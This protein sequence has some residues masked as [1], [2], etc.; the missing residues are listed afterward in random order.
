MTDKEEMKMR[1]S[2]FRKSAAAVLAVTL[3][4]AA[5]TGCGKKPA[6]TTAAATQAAPAATQAAQTAETKAEETQA[7]GGIKEGGEATVMIQTEPDSFDPF[8]AV[9]ADTESILF[10]V[11]DGLFV[12]K[13]DGTMAPDLAESY[14]VSDDHCTYTFHL[15]DGATF[16]NG[17]P[18]TVDDVVWTYQRYAEA[19]AGFELV[20]KIEAVDDKTMSITLKEPDASF[21]SLLNYGVAPHDESIDLNIT[22][23][24]SG[25]Y[26]ITDYVTGSEVTLEKNPHYNTNPDRVPHLDKVIVKVN[27][28]DPAVT[29]NQLMAGDIDLT[30]YMEPANAAMVEKRGFQV[31]A[32]P[33]NT[34]QILAFNEKEKPFDDVRVRQAVNYAVDKQAIIDT[35]LFGQSTPLFSHMSPVMAAYYTEDLKNT[36]TLDPA[37]AKELLKEAGYE[38]G[39]TFTIK[40]PSN[41]KRHVDTALMIKDQLAEVGINAE[42]EQIEWATWLQDVYTDRKFQATVVGMGGKVDPDK[43]LNRYES[44]YKRNMYNYN[45]PEYDALIAAGK[46]ETDQAK[47]V[48]IYKQCQQYLVDDAVCVYTMDTSNL[49]FANAKLGG[50]RN[51]P[52]YFIDM[53]ALYWT[54]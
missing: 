15:R 23:I 50:I 28:S 47:R 7:A 29:I 41:Y 39:V 18:V 32:A 16:S 25:P 43:V 3:A 45:N 46:A 36:Y 37:K 24:G 48:E 8:I 53:A 27:M 40:V 13:D 42:I 54:E 49:K 51:F 6:E 35:V 4:A 10:N 21:L 30:Q 44:S 9:A 52:A 26:M 17:N 19:K 14:E 12:L 38:N 11:Y 20:D 5:L 31:I 2:V 33:S 22:P 1:K 34:V